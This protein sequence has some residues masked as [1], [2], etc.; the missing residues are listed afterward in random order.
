M[1]QFAADLDGTDAIMLEAITRNPPL[2][3]KLTDFSRRKFRRLLKTTDKLSYVTPHPFHV[4]MAGFQPISDL[5][6]YW[7]QPEYK[8]FS[9]YTEKGEYRYAT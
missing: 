7:L 1:F 9:E 3:S 6:S 8:T 2:L 4:F 5:L